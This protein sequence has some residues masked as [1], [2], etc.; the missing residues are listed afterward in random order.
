MM[1]MRPYIP[2]IVLALLL[3]TATESI[4][5]N[6]N[7]H[8][9]SKERADASFARKTDI[10]GNL[11]R[12]T[13]FNNGMTGRTGTVPDEIAYEWPKNTGQHYLALTG[14]FVGGEVIDENGVTTK[15]VIAPAF[16][17]SPLGESWDWEPVPSYLNPNSSLIAKSTISSSWPDC[18][19]DKLE[20]LNDPGWCGSW[21]GFFGKDQFNAD[22][23]IF[24]KASDDLYSKHNYFP[25]STDLTRKG[26]GLILSSRVLEWSQVLVADVV[27]I[28]SEIKNDGT[29]S[30]DKAS[31]SM[32][33]ADLVGGDGDSSDDDPSFDQTN[34]VAWSKDKDG[35]GN[36]AFG[37]DPVG[38]V[39]STFLETPGNALD[40][41]DN[42]GDASEIENSALL[43]EWDET[44]VPNF[45]DTDF[46]PRDLLPG[47]KL[48]LIDP[49]DFSRRIVEYP[50]GG[51]TV[52]SMGI[53]FD[54]PAGGIA[55]LE[56]TQVQIHNLIDDDLDGLIDETKTLHL[57][58]LKRDGTVE[59]VRFIN[60]LAFDIGD[61]LKRG[62]LVPGMATPYSQSTVAPMIDESRGDLVDNDRDWFL[63]SD[64]VG[65]D[66]L[67]ES[68]DEGEFDGVPTSGFGTNLPGEPNID[69]TD[70]SESDQLGMT[71]AS[72]IAAGGVPLNFDSRMWSL[73]LTPGNFF[74]PNAQKPT[75]TD[76]FFNSG[77]FPLLAGET[78]RISMAVVLGNDEEDA[79]R[80]RDVALQAYL[81]DY[82]FAKAPNIPKLVA[83]SGDGYVTLYWDDFAEESFDRFMADRGLSGFDFEGYK[84]YRGTEPAFKD[85]FKITDSDGNLTFNKPIMVFDKIDGII[86][87][88]PDDINGIKFYL[89]DDTGLKHYWTDNDVQ[90]GQTYYYA[91]TSYDFGGPPGEG[92]TPSESPIAI[93]VQPDGS[94]LIGD[95]VAVVVPSVTAVGY[96]P[97]SLSDI[98]HIGSS[99]GEIFL[100]LIDPTEIID[101]NTYMITFQDTSKKGKKFSDPDTLTTKWFNL[102]SIAGSDTDTLIYQSDKFN[103]GDELPIIDGFLLSL[104][105]VEKIEFDEGPGKSGW[106]GGPDGKMD[107]IFRLHQKGFVLGEPLP[108]DYF[109]EIGELGM[110][111][112]RA[113]TNS[114]AGV[115]LPAI[116]VNFRVR[117]VSLGKYIDFAFWEQDFTGQAGVFSIGETTNDRII[118]IDSTV[119]GGEK[120]TWQ[121]LMKW[122]STSRQPQAG[123]T[124]FIF[125][126]KPFLSQDS[127]T[128]TT[129]APK[130]DIPLEKKEISKVRVVPNPYVAAASWEPRNPFST[131]RGPRS[132]HFNHVPAVCTIRIFNI[133]GELVDVI[134]VN[135]ALEDGT[136]EWNLLTRDNLE[137]SYG[138]YFFHILSEDGSSTTGK[139]AIIK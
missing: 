37:T 55:L 101:N 97:A 2:L 83:V 92:I 25:D 96:V 54:L 81:A 21:N 41:I 60:Y 76:L 133:V 136:A 116:E 73:A 34:D 58:R 59:P 51:G 100:E 82:Q 85:A 121:F 80:N 74:D 113:V 77:F 30:I 94:V 8:V 61:T 14:I 5:Q 28:I 9:P 7:G 69:K 88:H 36:D 40:G 139:F 70:V 10:D 84:I 39:A 63:S 3:S 24:F 42:D 104:K 67:K 56:T 90:N 57:T 102:I 23:E 128:F 99:T 64:D 6:D 71:G 138:I 62:L 95:N 107:I 87:L 4:A 47:D 11:V 91:V 110:A 26:L 115:E 103:E 22:Q 98:D 52:T 111:T 44:L 66:G 43:A 120:I 122:D 19:P 48:V 1:N 89:G 105:N 93:S 20:D 118:F 112:S 13:I 78:E 27:Y 109:I 18:W 125:L 16:R 137:V 135:N 114:E 131:G 130:I 45:Q 68:G 129:S 124:A 123:D 72:F 108:S 46:L 132:I 65:L 86:G 134:E 106:N 117:N 35:I 49:L 12:A 50:A 15:I 31:F 127:Y 38:V 79:I 29:K 17:Q 126:K 33:I 53:T 75:D 32:W 119:S